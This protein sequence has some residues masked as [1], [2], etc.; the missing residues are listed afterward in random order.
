MD[1]HSPYNDAALHDLAQQVAAA[2]LE[3][4]VMVATAESCTGG[5]IS[6]ALTG[7]RRQLGLV[8]GGRGHLQL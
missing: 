3:K 1:S 7:P 5:W 6:K 8:R 4:R 2:A